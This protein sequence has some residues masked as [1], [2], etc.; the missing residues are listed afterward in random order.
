M[1]KAARGSSLAAL[2][3]EDT[4]S[5]VKAWAAAAPWRSSTATTAQSVVLLK[6][7]STRVAP[8]GAVLSMMDAEAMELA[9]AP[10]KT[11]PRLT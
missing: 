6:V 2:R 11:W 8:A 3:P 9:S 7:P 4:V 1:L 10:W 5:A